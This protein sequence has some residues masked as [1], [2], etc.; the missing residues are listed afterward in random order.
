M[1]RVDSNSSSNKRIY[2]PMGTG[3]LTDPLGSP[4]QGHS[5]GKKTNLRLPKSLIPRAK[6][7]LL[8]D[9]NVGK[10]SIYRR[11]FFDDFDPKLTSTIGIYS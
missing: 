5:N 8:G 6:L 2:D 10:T 3:E 4:K 11:K 1:T 9:S 7:M